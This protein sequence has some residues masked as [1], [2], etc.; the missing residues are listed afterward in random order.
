[1]SSNIFQPLVLELKTDRMVL[2]VL[3]IVGSAAALLVAIVPASTALRIGLAALVTLITLRAVLEQGFGRSRAALARAEL[4]ADGFW[5][6]QLTGSRTS[7]LRTLT[8]GTRLGRWWFLY[9]G[10]AWAVVTPRTVGESDWR[11]LTGRLKHAAGAASRARNASS[12]G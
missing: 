6:L 5:R 4:L 1:M 3:A 7:A 11:R 10:T 8:S 9:W 2:A 12:R